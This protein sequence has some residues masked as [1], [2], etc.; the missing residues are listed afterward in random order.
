[1]VDKKDSEDIAD[2]QAIPVLDQHMN[3]YIMEYAPALMPLYMTL[4]P[5]SYLFNSTSAGPQK[6]S[7]HYDPDEPPYILL[8][9]DDPRYPG[10]ETE[11]VSLECRLTANKIT[12]CCYYMDLPGGGNYCEEA[13]ITL[14]GLWDYLRQI[15]KPYNCFCK[16]DD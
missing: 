2:T 10:G 8:G 5:F 6:N 16:G 1:M 3:D 4:L 12:M 13:E 7:K 11:G 15:P 9:I 14:S